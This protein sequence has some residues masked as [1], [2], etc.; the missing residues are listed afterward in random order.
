MS[1]INRLQCGVASITP[2]YS[3]PSRDSHAYEVL[4]ICSFFTLFSFFFEMI[5]SKIEDFIKR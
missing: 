4:G 3:G 1:D 5:Y 2:Y